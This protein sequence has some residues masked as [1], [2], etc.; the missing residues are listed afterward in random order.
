MLLKNLHLGAI[1]VLVSGLLGGLTPGLSAQEQANPFATALDV[2]TGRQLFIENMGKEVW[3]RGC[4]AK[5]GKER[6]AAAGLLEFSDGVL[7]QV[8]QIQN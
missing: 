4:L 6:Y 7:R 1:C 8:G 3:V 5:S 2:R